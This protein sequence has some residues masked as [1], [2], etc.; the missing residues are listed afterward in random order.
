[1]RNSRNRQIGS[2]PAVFVLLTAVVLTLSS[3]QAQSTTLLVCQH[4]TKI[5]RIR[6]FADQCPPA[7]QQIAAST[8]TGAAAGEG[9]QGPQGP[10]GPQ[11]PSGVVSISTATI[12]GVTED[13]SI[14]ATFEKLLDVATVEKASSTSLWK[15]TLNAHGAGENDGSTG[16][17]CTYQLRIDGADAA[18][19]TETGISTDYVGTAHVSSSVHPADSTL[20]GV[21]DTTV[22]FRDLPAGDHTISVYVRGNSVKSCMI[23]PGNYNELLHVEEI[24]PA[25]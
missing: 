5:K 1:M 19:N 6:F 24:E 3:A 21:I 12:S 2:I 8:I 22:I 10:T 20:S 13:E 14:S 18:G 9:A 23:N 4:K 25:N 15:L 7:F 17:T 16:F 11:G